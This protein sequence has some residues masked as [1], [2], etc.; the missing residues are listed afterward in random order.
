MKQPSKLYEIWRRRIQQHTE[1]H[2]T[3]NRELREMVADELANRIIGFLYE[4]Q[5]TPRIMKGRDT[6]LI[7]FSVSEYPA[8]RASMVQELIAYKVNQFQP[9]VEVVKF[10]YI[11]STEM[12][13]IHICP[14][15]LL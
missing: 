6:A 15:K 9:D 12:F 8:V 3:S 13:H 4:G 14:R 7:A 10:F 2:A 11:K 5:F 1:E